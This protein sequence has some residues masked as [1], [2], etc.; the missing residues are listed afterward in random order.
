MK[1]V[2]FVFFQWKI[3]R[4]RKIRSKLT[5]KKNLFMFS[6]RKVDFTYSKCDPYV[7]LC[8]LLFENTDDLISFRKLIKI[9]L[10]NLKEQTIHVKHRL[11]QNSRN[12]MKPLLQQKIR[13]LYNVSHVNIANDLVKTVDRSIFSSVHTTLTTLNAQSELLSLGSLIYLFSLV[14]C[15]DNRAYDSMLAANLQEQLK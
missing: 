15:F 2:K 6:K 9:K 13:H 1:T 10:D 12:N 4:K 8:V 11:T 3:F 7:Q 5:Q 14:C